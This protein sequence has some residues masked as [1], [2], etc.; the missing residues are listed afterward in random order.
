MRRASMATLGARRRRPQL[1][2]WNRRAIQRALSRIA[3]GT[4]G[5]YTAAVLVVD[6]WCLGRC[7]GRCLERCL[8]RCLRR[9][10]LASRQAQAPHLR[11]SAYECILLATKRLSTCVSSEVEL[12]RTCVP[13][14]QGSDGSDS[15]S[16]WAGSDDDWRDDALQ[17]VA[18]RVEAA[19]AEA[20]AES[21]GVGSRAAATSTVPRG[22][23]AAPPPAP[24]D[25]SSSPGA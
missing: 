1:Q 2:A 10:R 5:W 8:G 17:A 11:A 3:P 20:E 6:A 16:G 21:V 19:E 18:T 13:S 4:R 14:G 9:C 22:N 12:L 25:H 7:L 24:T 23:A 15:S